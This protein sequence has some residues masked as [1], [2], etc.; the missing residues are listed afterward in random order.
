MCILNYQNISVEM[1]TVAKNSHVYTKSDAIG[2]VLHPMHKRIT[3]TKTVLV[4]PLTLTS[5]KL[6]LYQKTTH[7]LVF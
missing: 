5:I 2:D 1:N 7:Q 6:V 4:P 3:V